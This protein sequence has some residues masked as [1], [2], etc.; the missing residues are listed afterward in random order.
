MVKS[1][2]VKHLRTSA[3][4][5]QLYSPVLLRYAMENVDGVF[6][7]DT[8]IAHMRGRRWWPCVDECVLDECVCAFFAACVRVKH[9]VK[10][11]RTRSSVNVCATLYE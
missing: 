9:D 10:W 6:R 8:A 7:H 1:L 5:S 11:K 4:C 3:F 2:T